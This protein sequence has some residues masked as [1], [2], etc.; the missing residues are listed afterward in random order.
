M[1]QAG[2]LLEWRRRHV[3]R[4]AIAYA[5]V[6]WVLVQLA[7]TVFPIFGAPVWVLKV[8][9]ALLTLGFPVAVILAWAFEMMPDGVHRTMPAHSD[10]ARSHEQTR[11]VGQKL[12]LKIIAVLLLAVT[13]L[14]WR[15]FMFHPAP[16]FASIT[17]APAKSIAVPPLVNESGDPEEQYFS[18]G[19][20]EDLIT[21]LS[22][23][24]GLKVIGRNSA[25]Q[26]RDSKDDPRYA[27]TYAALSR[28]WSGL[29]VQY[30]D[31][32]PARNRPIR[33]R[34][35]RPITRWRWIPT[36]RPRM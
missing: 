4:V 31:S 34:A 9:L 27:L 23:F 20:S 5:V 24:A 19:L 16:A 13:V 29:G 1:L 30:L 17:V 12:N 25:F 11:R 15:Q 28:V 6:A 10:E 22:Q 7:A 3:V 8:F 35:R 33:G 26:F 21:A 18:D 32:A 2:F 14:A 36:W